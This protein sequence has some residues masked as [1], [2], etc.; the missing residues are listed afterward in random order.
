MSMR[1]CELPWVE[2]DTI[3]DVPLEA[4]AEQPPATKA[5][6]TCRLDGGHGWPSFDQG[7]SESAATN[8]RWGRA[9]SGAESPPKKPLVRDRPCVH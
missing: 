6:T 9:C 1:L 8:R 4:G 3:P 5:T 7:T 2:P